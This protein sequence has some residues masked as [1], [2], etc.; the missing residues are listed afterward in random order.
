[1]K[2]EIIELGLTPIL[3]KPNVDLLNERLMGLCED[4]WTVEQVFSHRELF[5]VRWYASV[6]T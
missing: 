1:M 6:R 4:G 3:V 5:G 2:Q